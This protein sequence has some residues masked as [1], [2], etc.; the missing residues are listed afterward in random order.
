MY[1]LFSPFE[2]H[3]ANAIN[4]PA[5]GNTLQA[6]NG[7]TFI[8]GFVTAAIL[9]GLTVGVLI[10]F[11]NL[12][13]G[14]VAYIQSGGDKAK[15]EAARSRITNALVGIVVLFTVFVILNVVGAFLG[16]NLTL[17]NLDSLQVK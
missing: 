13:A 14:G 17:L 15:T 4:N 1:S 5:L 3:A 9:I 8:Q 7:V 6:L 10:F 11:F 12:I 16:T 2:I